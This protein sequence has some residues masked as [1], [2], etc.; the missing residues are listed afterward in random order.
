MRIINKKDSSKRDVFVKV[1]TEKVTPNVTSDISD[2]NQVVMTQHFKEYNLCLLNKNG[3]FDD[4]AY[5]NYQI[6][7]ASGN[8]LTADVINETLK[9]CHSTLI[10]EETNRSRIRTNNPIQ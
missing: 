8:V 10:N 6:N 7:D 2:F 4:S 9:T 5:D 1:F 3:F